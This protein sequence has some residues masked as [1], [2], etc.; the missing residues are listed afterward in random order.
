MSES[1]S[2]VASEM[3]NPAWISVKASEALHLK[4]SKKK[5]KSDVGRARSRVVFF[6]Y[7]EA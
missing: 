4:V 6:F 5:K 2:K 3:T 1:G 7:F